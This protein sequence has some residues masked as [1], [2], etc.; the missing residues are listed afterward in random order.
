MR[1]DFKLLALL[2]CVLSTL[3]GGMTL[4]TLYLL[5]EVEKID[6]TRTSHLKQLNADMRADLVALQNEYL[7]V[8][9]RLRPD[10]AAELR[11]RAQPFL[12]QQ[13][14]HEGRAG[15]KKRFP[16]RKNRV[17]RRDLQH[18]GRI[19]VEP[20]AKAR[21]SISYGVFENGTYQD[22]IHELIVRG[23]T[24]DDVTAW[25]IELAALREQGA[26]GEALKT[27]LASLVKDIS[28]LAWKVEKNRSQF[29]HRLAVA[30]QLSDDADDMM[31]TVR[32]TLI[33]AAILIIALAILS[34][35]AGT[36]LLVTKPLSDL[37]DA[38]RSLAQNKFVP[39]THI[40]RKD[41]IG[42]LS[43]SLLFLRDANE[44]KKA[45]EAEQTHQQSALAQRAQRMSD[46]IDTFQTTAEKG[47]CIVSTASASLAHSADLMGHT[48]AA[49]SQ[50]A[51]Q[52]MSLVHD[53][54]CAAQNVATQANVLMRAINST[55]EQ[56]DQCQMRSQDAVEAVRSASTSIGL[57]ENRSQQIGSIVKLIS[58]ITDQTNLLALNAT[59]EAAR[60]GESGRGF[61]VVADE[62]KQLAGQTQQA[63]ADIN[64]QVI[65]IQAA[66]SET[67]SRVHSIDTFI[68]LINDTL[69]E[70]TQI[71]FTQN[72]TVST[73]EID[74]Q[75][76]AQ[77]TKSLSG[78]MRE[79]THEA[80]K[81]EEVA[82]R[83][84]EAS[85]TLTSEAK[86]LGQSVKGF[87]QNVRDVA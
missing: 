21:I 54:E 28:D 40:R 26:S 81:T 17:H 10:A 14:R 73:I 19:V 70:T 53:A 69:S 12:H 13:I 59:I 7:A 33:G 82:L 52:T 49:S 83:V 50:K 32:I 38:A 41:E 64:K 22:Q 80:A 87:L 48:C 27:A 85:T 78:A 77:S 5:S 58:E 9:Q 39:L 6:T 3:M 55:S 16:G 34:V 15:L 8:P 74:I 2:G 60:A 45:L 65:S 31:A 71:L 11:K 29:S 57:L 4:S 56:I 86:D 46:L 72:K 51:S 23:P 36:R 68:G 24:L 61:A 43:R 1:I 63:T 47:L 79:V 35:Y 76:V 62:V 30:N 44:R 18:E 67:I 20:L 66:I 37:N 42:T 75:Q 25:T 84:G